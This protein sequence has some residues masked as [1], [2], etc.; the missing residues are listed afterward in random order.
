VQQI[1]QVQ[2]AFFT[3]EEHYS[4]QQRKNSSRLHY[5]FAYQQG[6][7]QI[8]FHCLNTAWVSRLK[9]Q[10]GQLLFPHFQLSHTQE[11]PDLVV[12]V[13]HHP[14]A[15]LEPGNRREFRKLVESFSDV[16]LTGHEHDGDAYIRDSSLDEHV[17]YVEGAA[18]QAAGVDT[19]FNF[20]IVDPERRSYQALR[21]LKSGQIYKPDLI[22]DAAFVRNPSLLKQYFENKKYSRVQK[23][24]AT[25]RCSIFSPDQETARD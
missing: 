14:Y 17:H 11:L 9:E 22:K 15:W 10:P 7:K 21:F 6:D 12:S 18:F 23:G 1:A 8:Q 4:K 13:F 24:F 16:V 2:D 25:P 5:F 20:V 19:G 3:F